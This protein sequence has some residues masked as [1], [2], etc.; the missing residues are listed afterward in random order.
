MAKEP[1]KVFDNLYFLGT[2][3]VASYVISTSDGLIL[4]DTLYGGPYT[5]YLIEN[6]RKMGLDIADVKYVLIMQGH[7]DHY[8]GARELQDQHTKALF[9]AAEEDWKMIEADLGN[10]AP[11]RDFVIEEGD[12]LTLGDT[13]IN[14]E[15]TPG[16]TPGTT[17]MRFAVFDNGTRHEAYFHGG[18]AVRSRDAGVI[19]TFIADLERIGMIPDIE[20]QITNHFDTAAT[21]AP[22]LFGRAERLARRKPGEPHPWV[23][24]DDFH[25]WI[26]ETVANT[27]ELLADAQ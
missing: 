22:D 18:A 14:F 25:A 21:G 27:R 1:F 4:L 24:P 2:G 11:R 12:S 8:G 5:G 16:H 20:V 3:E 7:W 23:A 9:G 10:Q 15:I 6:M 26:D 13:T 19:R 17:S